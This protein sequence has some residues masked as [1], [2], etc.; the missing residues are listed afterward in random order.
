MFSIKTIVIL[1]FLGLLSLVFAEMSI[2]EQISAIKTASP[3]QRVQMMNDLKRNIATMQASQRTDTIN[4]LRANLSQ[5]PVLHDN[6]RQNEQMKH[7]NDIQ[8]SEIMMQK[9]AADRF[10]Q[11]NNS[12]MPSHNPPPNQLPPANRP[13]P[14]NN[15][16]TKWSK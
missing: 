7:N 16:N 13:A 6:G 5:Q 3:E 9:G 8:H 11:Q 12:A 15:F 10:V 2:D 1:S 4:K 14:Q